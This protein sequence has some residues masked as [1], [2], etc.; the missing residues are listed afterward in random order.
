MN[1]T[2]NLHEGQNPPMSQTPI[3]IPCKP[4][5]ATRAILNE[6]VFIEDAGIGGESW[7]AE[8][9]QCYLTTRLLQRLGASFERELTPPEGKYVWRGSR[10]STSLPNGTVWW[11]DEAWQTID[12][13][14]MFDYGNIYASPLPQTDSKSAVTSLGSG[15]AS[16]LVEDCVGVQ[17][18]GSQGSGASIERNMTIQ[19]VFTNAGYPKPDS[20]DKIAYTRGWNLN[21]AHW[22]CIAPGACYIFQSQWFAA[23]S[24]YADGIDLSNLPAADA[25]YYLPQDIQAWMDDNP[26]T[27]QAAP[28]SQE[29]TPSQPKEEVSPV[30]PGE[31][32]RSLTNDERKSMPEGTE[33]RHSRCSSTAWKLAA[34]GWPASEY[35]EYRIPTS[36]PAKEPF[37][38]SPMQV[39]EAC[40]YLIPSD[41]GSGPITIRGHV[42][43]CSRDPRISSTDIEERK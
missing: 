28:N 27:K 42:W 14:C 25:Y 41:G 13:R 6:V 15:E 4:E 7:M 26:E 3:Y 24:N 8:N 2:S 11:Q 10:D 31:G 34:V 32:Y 12:D 9:D 39:V 16:D 35:Y 22:Y 33:F 40:G 19:E 38:E 20:T 37:S 43:A 17:A 21:G 23:Q 30:S 1:Q 29:V 18:A 5:E 36:T